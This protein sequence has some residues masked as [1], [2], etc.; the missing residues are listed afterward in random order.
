MSASSQ[1][2][3]NAV[4][5]SPHVLRPHPQQQFDPAPG[6]SDNIS[7]VLMQQQQQS[8]SGMEF[9]PTPYVL[10]TTEEEYALMQQQQQQQQQQQRLMLYQQQQQQQ[11]YLQMYLL[12]QQQ[13]LQEQE[14]EQEQD[15]DQ[16]QEQDLEQEQQ[17][18]QGGYSIGAQMYYG[19]TGH[20]PARASGVRRP[21][22]MQ[23]A[24]V[25]GI[26]GPP[27]GGGGGPGG[28]GNAGMGMMGIPGMGIMG[29]GMGMGVGRGGNY[30][31]PTGLGQA[32]YITRQS[33]DDFCD[34][35]PIPTHYVQAP[36]TAQQPQPYA[37]K[38]RA[39]ANSFSSKLNL[40]RAA[41]SGYQN[42]QPLTQ[43]QQRQL[44]MQSLNQQYP[45]YPHHVVPQ[46]MFQQSAMHQNSMSTQSQTT[47]NLLTVINTERGEAG[48]HFKPA[49]LSTDS[50]A[51]TEKFT[52][53]DPHQSINKELERRLPTV[54]SQNTATTKETFSGEHSQQIQD[55]NF[56][57][58]T[59]VE[60]SR[61]RRALSFDAANMNEQSTGPQKAEIPPLTGEKEK[62]STDV[63][64]KEPN[65]HPPTATSENEK[66]PDSSSQETE[67]APV[68]PGSS[69]HEVPI[70][71]SVALKPTNMSSTV[72][73]EVDASVDSSKKLATAEQKDSTKSCK[74]QTSCLTNNCECFRG[75]LRCTTVCICTLCK[76]RPGCTDVTFIEARN[77]NAL[78][79][80]DK[81]RQPQQTSQN[82]PQPL[83]TLDNFRF[84][85]KKL[86]SEMMGLA[87]SLVAASTQATSETPPVSKQDAVLNE[88]SKFLSSLIE[89]V[90]EQK[91]NNAL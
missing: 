35:A 28:G 65:V 36:Y 26:M 52:P 46:Q 64:S 47:D 50:T 20:R 48:P 19:H 6:S 54:T 75:S 69:L 44:Q 91:L 39:R 72:G 4:D 11:Q 5:A 79:E 8:D 81:T 24:T 33:P 25:G 1:Q 60:Q 62:I 3:N 15:R 30:E 70:N 87:H 86:N 7:N 63:T 82:E 57:A 90:S 80:I 42:I 2:H 59:I 14:A 41:T 83:P 51:S 88:F 89:S 49:Q 45:Y 21:C 9:D 13:Q 73:K 58:Q 61:A 78:R 76:N 27:G 85:S 84:L 37:P 12:Q 68:A 29:M 34:Y 67:M 18:A 53:M 77:I 22:G 10:G 40:L 56:N 66:I 17:M 55:H 38:R 74:C 31:Y 71:S 23:D 16:D 43:Q 32:Q